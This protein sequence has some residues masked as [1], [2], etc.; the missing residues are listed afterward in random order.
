MLYNMQ[1]DW[2]SLHIHR[3]TLFFFPFFCFHLNFV[4]QFPLNFSLQFGFINHTINA[5]CFRHNFHLPF[6]LSL[7][8]KFYCFNDNVI[9]SF[10]FEFNKNNK[11][12]SKRHFIDPHWICIAVIRLSFLCACN[13]LPLWKMLRTQFR[14]VNDATGQVVNL[15]IIRWGLFLIIIIVKFGG[16]VVY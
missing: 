3:A 12:G 2:V 11:N 8:G 15:L 4:Q 16:L 5:L 10:W 7:F 9:V 1:L 13:I 6:S 14:L